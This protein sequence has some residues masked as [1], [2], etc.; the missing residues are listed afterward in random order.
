MKDPVEG[1]QD[2]ESQPWPMGHGHG[3]WV[4]A[5]GHGSWVMGHG[6][7]A[8]GHGPWVTQA[9]VKMKGAS[10]TYRPPVSLGIYIY[11]YIY[12]IEGWGGSEFAFRQAPHNGKSFRFGP[13]PWGHGPWAMG[14]RPW[15]IGHP[16]K[17]KDEGSV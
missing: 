7:G 2:P 14:H 15:A 11:I 8:M 6:H 4:M 16:G 9:S 3:S 10:R 13:W 17:C 1:S 5:M 12:T